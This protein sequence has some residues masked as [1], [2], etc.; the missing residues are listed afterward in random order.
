M[1][2]PEEDD[3]DDEDESSL[4]VSASSSHSSSSQISADQLPTVKF[5]KGFALVGASGSEPRIGV[6]DVGVACSC[7]SSRK[8]AMVKEMSLRRYR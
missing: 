7:P 4:E 8:G 1:V 3:G 2:G 5:A 6:L